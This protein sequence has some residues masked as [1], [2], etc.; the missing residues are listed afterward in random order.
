MPLYIL[1]TWRSSTRQPEATQST[2]QRTHLGVAQEGRR[3]SRADERPEHVDKG[4][5]REGE[6]APACDANRVSSSAA[7]QLAADTHGT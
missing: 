6:E 3:A 4:E 1:P 5:H 7:V 2:L